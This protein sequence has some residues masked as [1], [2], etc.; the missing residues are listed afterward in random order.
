MNPIAAFGSMQH[1]LS[2]TYNL[3]FVVT[4]CVKVLSGIHW[5][6][7]F[8][9]KRKMVESENVVP[10]ALGTVLSGALHFA[11][12]ILQKA[13]AGIAKLILIATRIDEC[14]LR[15][16][17]L[18]R[19]FIRLKDAFLGRFSPVMEP[20]WIK[21]PESIVLSA[22]TINKWK[23]FGK[24][25]TAYIRGIYY[26]L[27]DIFV[28]VF[29]LGMQLWDAYHAFIYSHDEVAELFVNNMYWFRK[30]RNNQDYI[31]S[32]LEEYQPILKKFFSATHIPFD[33]T[34]ITKKVVNTTVK[35]I[36]A[37]E[38]AN[39]FVGE[40]IIKPIK[41]V[42]YHIKSKLLCKDLEVTPVHTPFVL[43]KKPDINWQPQPL[44]AN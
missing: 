31:N 23:A 27:L 4:V 12:K 14:I 33:I 13:I 26:S 36:E 16:K 28:K 10:A 6:W 9:R 8:F 20:K 24:N 37:I 22:H 44:K 11:P 34:S 32:K 39:K 15:M 29:K 2:R 3:P 17:T 43:N 30:I 25:F 41:K 7:W 35:G 38:N 42:I 21:H 1:E 40:K 19:A 18:A 5:V